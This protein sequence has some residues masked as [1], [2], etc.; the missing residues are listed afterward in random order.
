[1]EECFLAEFDNICNVF[2][3][4]DWGPVLRLTCRGAMSDMSN[5]LRDLNTHIRANLTT[6]CF[7]GF[8]ILDLISRLA[9]SMES[10]TGELKLSFQDALKPIRD[11]AKSSL[12]ELLDDVRQRVTNIPSIP[13]DAAV[14]PVTIETMQR[15]QNMTPYMAPLSSIL[16][17]LGDGN[18][19][20]TAASNNASSTSLPSL[21]SFDV[22]ADGRKLL[23][24]YAM[25]NIEVLMQNLES[26][27]RNQQ[28]ATKGKDNK[29]NTLLGAFLANNVAII[30]RMIR[31]SD[32]APLLT[33]SMARIDFWRKKGK[34]LY[35]DAWRETSTFLL[36]A[37]H[38][39]RG[40][41][42]PPSGSSSN[43]NSA[44]VVKALSGKEKDVIK[45]KFRNFNTSFDTLVERHKGFMM[46]REVRAMLGREIQAMIEPLYCRF[47]DRY[48]EIDK[49]KGKYV[50]YDKSQLVGILAGLG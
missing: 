40:G 43:I 3:R 50:K 8:E 15:L 24:H 34:T 12:A 6:D 18:W 28:A 16:T 10:K 21:K 1:M 35:S 48:H 2:G 31:T 49:G 23:G 20:S 5:A 46:E 7:L 22:G 42:R 47:W 17:A 41:Q 11:T 29:G 38:T 19:T 44:E 9:A 26:R 36:D 32:L 13:T 27:G 4:D 33:D 45:D 14:V 39:N 37:V 30:E 25:D